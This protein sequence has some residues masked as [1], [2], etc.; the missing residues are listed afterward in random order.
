MLPDV[1]FVGFEQRPDLDRHFKALS[2]D[3]A[4]EIGRWANRVEAV[5][6][7]KQAHGEKPCLWL[8][9]SLTLPHDSSEDSAVAPVTDVENPADF[10]RWIRFV[11]GNVLDKILR[12]RADEIDRE[13]NE[14]VGG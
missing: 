1:R 9:L 4:A 14:V 11:W 5:L 8:T 6:E 12:K 3:I 2:R 7:L 13:M 10:R